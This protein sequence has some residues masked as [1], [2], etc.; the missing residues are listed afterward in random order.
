MENEKKVSEQN[1]TT[2]VVAA[3]VQQKENWKTR[4]KN[5]GKKHKKGLIA[6]AIALVGTVL[7]CV[8][9]KSGDDG[10]FETNETAEVETE[11][12]ITGE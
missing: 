10:E 5:F 11:V 6:G 12:E 1:E 3:P 2:A 9:R 8:T 4:A 7:L